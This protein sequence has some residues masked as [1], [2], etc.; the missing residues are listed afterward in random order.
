MSVPRDAIIGAVILILA[1][2]YWLAAGRIPRSA[3]EDAVG[4][5]GLPNTLAAVLA[6]LAILLII[7]GFLVRP[8]TAAG[9]EVGIG[10]QDVP[11]AHLRA[12]GMVGLGVGYLLIVPVLGYAISVALLLAAVSLYNGYS[13]APRLAIF[14]IAGAAFFYILFVRAFSIPLPAG[15][16]P[17]LLPI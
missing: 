4:A 2:I 14:A 10:G 8:S 13:P 12:I 1:G 9:G 17:Q 3:L 6:G 15:F 11:R 16:W 5:A 7:R